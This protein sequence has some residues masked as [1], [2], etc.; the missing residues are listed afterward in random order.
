MNAF[1]VAPILFL[2]VLA[3]CRSSAER[4]VDAARDRATSCLRNAAEEIALEPVDLDTA[5]AATMK[6]CE[7][8]LSMERSASLESWSGFEDEAVRAGLEKIR[9]ARMQQAR[10]FIAVERIR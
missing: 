9:N 4:E 2:V 8:E 3:A 1:R 10:S 6:R 7:E 5:A